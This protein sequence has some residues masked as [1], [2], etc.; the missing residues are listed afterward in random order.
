V[1]TQKFV[2]GQKLSIDFFDIER[3]GVVIIPEAQ[4]VLEREAAGT[5][6]PGEQVIRNPD[7]SINVV[8]RA[9]QNAGFEKARGADFGLQYSRETSWGT[10]TWITQATFLDEFLRQQTPLDPIERLTRQTATDASDEGYYQWRGDSRFEWAW[11]GFSLVGTV[12][13]YDGFHEPDLDGLEHWVSQ[14]WIFDLQGSYTFLFPER[15]ESSPV[16]G[17]SKAANAVGKDA[18]VSMSGGSLWQTLLHDTRITVGCNNVFDKDPPTAFGGGNNSVGYPGFTY[19]A[20][21]QFVYVRL[22]KKF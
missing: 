7:G 4:Q 11:K 18:S 1:Y 12:R 2:P 19:D 14:T 13:Y 3:T 20:T 5:L 16:A 8:I 22:S 10:F 9:D 15:V 17:Y 6:L 21:G